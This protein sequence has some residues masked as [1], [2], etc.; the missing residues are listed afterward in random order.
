MTATVAGLS[1]W[2]KTLFGSMHMLRVA[3]SIAE[4]AEVFT[5]RELEGATSLAPSTVHRLLSDLTAVE[6]LDR[7]PRE[8]GER[9]QRYGRRPHPFWSAAVQ[10]TEEASGG[11]ASTVSPETA[12]RE[13]G[14]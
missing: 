3:D 9:H 8:P 14:S 2:S 13:A 11:V 12:T 10:F 7:L 1:A 4:A 6:L 5:A